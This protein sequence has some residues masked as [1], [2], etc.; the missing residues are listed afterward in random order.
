MECCDAGGGNVRAPIFALH[1]TRPNPADARVQVSFELP[2][3]MPG[4]LD[5]CDLA[6]RRVAHREIGGL[7]PGLHTVSLGDGARIRPGVCLVRLH[8][9]RSATIR[10]IVVSR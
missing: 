2:S 9:G 4:A 8:Q 10:K 3:T 6:G 5:L 7:E 1:G